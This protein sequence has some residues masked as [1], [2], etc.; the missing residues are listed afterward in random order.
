MSVNQ[1]DLGPPPPLVPVQ[2]ELNHIINTL[3]SCGIHLDRIQGEAIKGSLRDTVE[4]IPSYGVVSATEEIARLTGLID[5]RLRSIQE[6]L[7]SL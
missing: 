3:R 7:G 6:R 4:Q 1:A 2:A 5:E